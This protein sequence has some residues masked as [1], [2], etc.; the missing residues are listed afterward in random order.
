MAYFL[1]GII[2]LFFVI[3]L[4]ATIYFGFRARKNK[5]TYQKKFRHS[6]IATIVLF[7]F[8]AGSSQLIP[9][10]S[11]NNETKSSTSSKQ[12]DIQSS[13]S[14]RKENKI[15]S[16]NDANYTKSEIKKIN[17]QLVLAL[18]NDQ[19]DANNGD[20]RYN[21]ANYILKILIQKNKTAYVYVDGNFMNLSE[22]DRKIVGEHTNGL[23]GAA[24]A[25]AGIDYTPEEGREGVYMSFYNG[26]QAI[27]RSRYTDNTSFKWYK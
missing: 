5:E 10:T 19:K 17:H 12:K 21:W 14:S 24:I 7:I 22:E 9:D 1:V 25:M 6:I 20:E 3:S 15:K 2:D 8:L 16:S 4:I 27:G 23:I 18:K 26:P 13:S 11:T